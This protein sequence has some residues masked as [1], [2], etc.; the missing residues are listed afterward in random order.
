M[1]RKKSSIRFSQPNL[2]AKEQVLGSASATTSS[3]PTRGS[4]LWRARRMSLP[5]LLLR[6]RFFE[7]YQVFVNAIQFLRQK[8]LSSNCVTIFND[9]LFLK[10][11]IFCLTLFF[12][13]S[14]QNYIAV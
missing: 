10:L 1:S 12:E 5:S 14:E 11:S 3:R 9:S 13:Y 8:L 6:C 2:P 4:Y 7:R